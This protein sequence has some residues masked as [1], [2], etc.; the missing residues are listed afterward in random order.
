MSDTDGDGW[1]DGTEI[2][3]GSVPIDVKS[4]PINKSLGKLIYNENLNPE[5][6]EF[7]FSASYGFRY[8]VQTSKDLLEWSTVER[9]II[10]EGATVSR[11]FPINDKALFYRAIN[12]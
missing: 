12:K 9:G 10:G 11:I 6:Y 8:S 5:S 4:K 2:E 7:R 1:N 3:F